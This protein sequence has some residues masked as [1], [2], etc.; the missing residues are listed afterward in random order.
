MVA[1]IVATRQDN[2][3]FIEYYTLPRKLARN[4][5]RAKERKLLVCKSC[6]EANGI[7]A[8]SIGDKPFAVCKDGCRDMNNL[9]CVYLSYYNHPMKRSKE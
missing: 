9:K 4:R 7:L 3:Y 6:Y 8:I 2:F 5:H 1:C